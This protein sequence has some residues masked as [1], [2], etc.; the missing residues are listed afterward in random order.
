VTG[1]VSI[2][3]NMD[4]ADTSNL[5][6]VGTSNAGTSNAGISNAGISNA[7]I[8]NAGTS[9]AGIAENVGAAVKRRAA[10][11][12]GTAVAVRTAAG[13]T[14]SVGWPA[15]PVGTCQAAASSRRAA[16]RSRTSGVGSAS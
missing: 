15:H 5:G 8:S 3:S 10:V 7:G 2:G 14:A 16:Y 13:S 9:N 4:I 11:T 6:I 12:V 1:T